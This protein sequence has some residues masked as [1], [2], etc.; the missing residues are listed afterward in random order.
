MQL[1]SREGGGIYHPPQYELASP[2]VG[3]TV[4]A[5]PLSMNEAFPFSPPFGFATFFLYCPLSGHC[6]WVNIY[7]KKVII[8]FI[9]K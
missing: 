2:E 6:E 4:A 5:L 1:T 8:I 3:L 9:N 7:F